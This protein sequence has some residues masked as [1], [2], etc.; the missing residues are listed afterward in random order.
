MT[1]YCSDVHLYESIN[2]MKMKATTPTGAQGQWKQDRLE[3]RNPHTKNTI[4]C[5]ALPTY[6]K[7]L[8]AA[9]ENQFHLVNDW[10]VIALF[11][12]ED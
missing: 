3:V 11:S 12:A 7:F 9:P 6:L 5:L 1:V 10:T 8:L 2:K 4:Q